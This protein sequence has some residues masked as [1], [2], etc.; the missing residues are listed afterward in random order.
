MGKYT[1]SRTLETREAIETFTAVEC[2]SF[3]EAIKLVDKGIHDRKLELQNKEPKQSTVTG[4]GSAM[5][6]TGPKSS[7]DEPQ[8]SNV[9]VGTTP[10][11][12]A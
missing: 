11:G 3:D 7:P 6:I 2:A 12:K 10:G 9:G 5:P 4:S 8:G 1:Y